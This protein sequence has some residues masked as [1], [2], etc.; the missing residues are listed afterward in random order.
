MRTPGTCIETSLSEQG[1]DPFRRHQ[2]LT[3]MD[4]PPQ[5]QT[6]SFSYLPRPHCVPWIES[7]PSR[8]VTA[9]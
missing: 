6:L 4:S 7:S 2:Q 1:L 3:E 5:G 8:S 9:C